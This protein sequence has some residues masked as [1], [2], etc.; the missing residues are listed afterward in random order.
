MT[1]E[2]LIKIWKSSPNRERLKFEKSRLMVEMQASL[3]RVHGMIKFAKRRATIATLIIVP[4][5]TFYIYMIP[6]TLSKIASGLAVLFA[7]NAFMRFRKASK[8]EPKDFTGT[9]W[10]Y[11]HNT[12]NYLFDQKQLIDTALYWST[13]PGISIC[14][15]FFIGFMESPQ[16]T[17][18]TIIAL[19]VGCIVIGIII[20]F[21]SKWWVKVAI[22]P[23]L[24]NVDELI[25]TLEE[26]ESPS[27]E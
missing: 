16:F 9:Y 15:L 5:F 22:T 27:K 6:F 10:E 13:I 12:K 25:S 4:V 26:S 2:E 17:I 24:K 23:N 14:I 18:T 19:C 11:L 1:E 3:D 8:N 21:L 7:V 20:F